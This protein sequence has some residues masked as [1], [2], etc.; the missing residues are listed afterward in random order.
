MD[1]KVPKKIRYWVHTLVE[2]DLLTME[3]KVIKQYATEV[4]NE[5]PEPQ[6]EELP[7]AKQEGT[8]IL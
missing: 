7:E 1:L 6:K 4:K 2:L 5:K 8:V 3:S